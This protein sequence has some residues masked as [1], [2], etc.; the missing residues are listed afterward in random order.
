MLDEQ[1]MRLSEVIAL[2]PGQRI[3][4]EHGAK[5]RRCRSVAARSLM[6]EGRI[7]QKNNNVA[8]E[9]ENTI[10]R[11]PHRLITPASV[12]TYFLTLLVGIMPEHGMDT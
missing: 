12:L 2:R 7:G 6:F 11:G 3:A 1:T 5:E 10:A 8:V 4:A 9:I